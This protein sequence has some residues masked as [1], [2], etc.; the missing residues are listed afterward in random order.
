MC[1]LVRSNVY[2][3]HKIKYERKNIEEKL[4]NAKR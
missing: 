2:N 1:D 4:I 3:M